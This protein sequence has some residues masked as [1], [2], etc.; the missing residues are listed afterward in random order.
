M[1]EVHHESRRRLPW[2]I[3]LVGLG[4]LFV[5]AGPSRGDGTNDDDLLKEAQVI[6]K[7]LPKDMATPVFPVAPDRVNLGRKLFFDPR[8]SAD[9]TVS[10]MR[11][12]QASLYATDG[13]AKSRGAH[14][15]LLPRNAATVFNTAL[16]FKQHWRGEFENVEEQAKHALLGLGLANPDYATAM[17]RVKAIPGY[18]ELFKKAFPGEAD[19]VTEDNWGKA[20]GAYERTLVTPSRFDEY[21]GGKAD[22]LTAQER[23]GLRTFIDT[24][25][26]G[27]HNGVGVGGEKFRIIGMRP[28]ARR[29]TTGEAN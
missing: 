13:L 17:A 10:C 12:H 3:V 18:P 27:C 9:G 11:C 4:V 26:A 19:P 24:G 15:K 6:F 29:S 8:I 22:A 20:I 2:P 7:P 21:L 28:I 23:Q 25:C 16:Q 14:D 1:P 5:P